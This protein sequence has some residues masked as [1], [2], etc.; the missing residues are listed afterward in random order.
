MIFATLDQ[1]VRRG[2]LEDGL[3]IHYYSEF[4]YHSATSLR[5]LSF[6]TLKIINTVNL[7]VNEYGAFDLP[8]DFVDDLSVSVPV[9][10]D[11]F[12][13]PKQSRLS[14]L[15]IHS[16]VTGQF[17]PNTSDTNALN[18]TLA[19]E[20]LGFPIGWNLYWNVND[21]GE[22]TGRFYGASGGTQQGYQIF[23]ERR[24]GQMTGGFVCQDS[25]IVLMY[26]SDGQSLDNATQIDMQAFQT[27]RSFQEWKRSPNANDDNSPEGRAFYN[28]RRLL[29]AR[30]NDLTRVDILNIIR[31]AYTAAMKN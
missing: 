5:E 2:L 16:P 26:I 3:P 23:K 30:L 9:G 8:G 20:F 14:P 4:F 15:R 11:L 27:I 31:Q 1:I 19:N 24:Q 29:R 13:L 18:S 12:D 6:D 10:G 28:Q 21:Y 17:V 25:N 7:P 22:P